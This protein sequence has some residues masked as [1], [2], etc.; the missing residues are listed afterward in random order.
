MS[1]PSSPQPVH[2][3]RYVIAERPRISASAVLLLVLIIM[4]A[5]SIFAAMSYWA[6]VQ[7]LQ[8]EVSLL[9]SELKNLA[10]Q[11]SVLNEH[12]KRYRAIDELIELYIK[13]LVIKTYKELF[14]S[15][16]E[17]ELKKLLGETE[18]SASSTTATKTVTTTIKEVPI[19]A[20]SST[21][22]IKK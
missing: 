21:V 8:N 17:E 7:E 20:S 10:S 13:Q 9:R 15:L 11:L 4:N 18:E 1:E 3:E 16:S 12:M 19:N 6:R 22:V 5:V 14:P 2:S